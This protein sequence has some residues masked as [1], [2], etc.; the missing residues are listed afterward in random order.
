MADTETAN[1]P[2]LVFGLVGAV[3]T[4]LEFVQDCLRDALGCVQYRT[5]PIHLSELLRA[6]P[7]GQEL[8]A[9]PEDERLGV[10]MTAGNRLREATKRGDA[11]AL[12]AIGRIRE[13][14]TEYHGDEH[15]GSRP[16]PQ[17]AYVL[18]SLKHDSE[19]DR[20]RL[21]YGPGFFLIGAYAPHETRRNC[22][23]EAIARSHG[24]ADGSA[25]LQVADALIERDQFEP[26]T[27]FGQRVRETFSKADVF[28]DVRNQ[29]QVRSEIKR[30]V[31]ILFRHPN[32]TPSRHEYAMFH[33]SAAAV[34]S[35]SLS[36]Q[37]GAAIVSKDGEIIAT[38]TNEVPR[39]G[40]GLYWPGDTK[41]D[42]RDFRL[43]YDSN[44]RM[45]IDV[46]RQV[47]RL[48][49]NRGWLKSTVADGQDLPPETIT[50]AC[51]ILKDSRLMNLTEFGREVHAEMAGL[52]D[53]ARRGV[54]VRDASLYCTTFPCH[55]C[56]KHIIAA[57]IRRVYYIEPYPKSLASDLHEDAIAVEDEDD[58]RLPFLPFVGVGARRYMDFFSMINSEG[59]KVD[60]KDEEGGAIRWDAC[61]S[62]PRLPMW[63][64]SY[65]DREKISLVDFTK[66][67]EMLTAEVK[68][69]CHEGSG[70]V[71]ERARCRAGRSGSDAGVEAL[72]SGDRDER[73]DAA[74]ATAG[75]AAGE[76][77]LA[78]SRPRRGVEA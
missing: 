32:H 55:N 28:I 3:G 53:A 54:P 29:D 2:E 70:L 50:E 43:G 41:R 40:G 78:P 21:V 49:G 60:R 39:P 38:G 8:P 10:Y 35:A 31:E 59:W 1:N 58:W 61:R 11:L 15:A 74:A 63:E 4:D 27:P 18:R 17:C 30:F 65:V 51:E 46:V 37:V 62:Y 77:R 71:E 72:G 22:L 24:S 76:G 52:L 75:A 14:R 25:Y 6:F 66:S 19:V 33:A 5:Q 13:F 48:F 34:R 23:A 73:Y 67:A 20:L 7:F 64:R 69:S 56:A 42:R 44:T 68:G 57:G 26:E 16:V 9:K 12:L 47:L 36:R 45:K